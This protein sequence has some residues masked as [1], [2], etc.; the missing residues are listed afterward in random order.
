MKW[1]MWNDIEVLTQYGEKEYNEQTACIQIGHRRREDERSEQDVKNEK[2]RDWIFQKSREIDKKKKQYVVRAYLSMKEHMGFD[3]RQVLRF[4]P[5][6]INREAEVNQEKNACE[7]KKSD[8][9]Q[10]EPK[11][12]ADN[13]QR[14]QD[15]TG[16]YPSQINKPSDNLIEVRVFRGLNIRRY[17]HSGTQ[18]LALKEISQF[19]YLVFLEGG[20]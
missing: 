8:E 3:P 2:I 1:E 15:D 14:E 5:V 11:A 13:Q 12:E 4:D 18:V 20:Q 19:R 10:L 7:N 9:G 17:L 16:G 6:E